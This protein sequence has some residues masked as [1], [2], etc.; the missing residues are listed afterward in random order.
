MC[1]LISPLPLP[2]T[3]RSESSAL[4]RPLIIVRILA[5]REN[6]GLRPGT[7]SR[8]EIKWLAAS[9]RWDLKRPILRA[10][11]QPRCSPR[12]DPRP[13]WVQLIRRPISVIDLRSQP[14]TARAFKLSVWSQNHLQTSRLDQARFDCGNYRHPLGTGS[15]SF[16][17]PADSSKTRSQEPNI[18]I[19]T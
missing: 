15:S 12:N 13:R 11:S 10:H 4:T 9:L 19:F 5:R 8:S 14:A 17:E 6:F 18:R 7:R 1:V 3:S 2:P 16:F